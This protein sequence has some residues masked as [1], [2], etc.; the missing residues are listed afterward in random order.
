MRNQIQVR[1]QKI[2]SPQNIVNARYDLFTVISGKTNNRII[3]LIDKVSNPSKK[4]P[5]NKKKTPEAYVLKMLLIKTVCQKYNG[6]RNKS[7]VNTDIKK[8]RIEAIYIVLLS[9]ENN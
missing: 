5:N 4:T 7:H 6:Y 2:Q 9:I 8:L 1:W 3:R